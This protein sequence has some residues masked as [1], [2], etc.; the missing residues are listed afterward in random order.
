MA[1]KIPSVYS[2]DSIKI[3]EL[4]MATLTSIAILCMETATTYG[5]NLGIIFGICQFISYKITIGTPSRLLQ[6]TPSRKWTLQDVPSTSS[7]YS[8][9]TR[10]IPLSFLLFFFLSKNV[11]EKWKAILQ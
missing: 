9:E 2:G 1:T 8:I 10:W 7:C 3:L 5:I 6:C 4:V 11:T